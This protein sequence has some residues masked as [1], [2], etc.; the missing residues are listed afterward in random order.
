MN[1]RP[2]M[3]MKVSMFNDGQ[4]LLNHW[5]AIEKERRIPWDVHAYRMALSAWSNIGDRLHSTFYSTQTEGF[6]PTEQGLYAGKWLP[7][8]LTDIPGFSV[9]ETESALAAIGL[10]G[11][12]HPDVDHPPEPFGLI[13]TAVTAT[14]GDRTEV[15]L[16]ADGRSEFPVRYD[17]SGRILPWA[18]ISEFGTLSLVPAMTGVYSQDVMATDGLGVEVEFTLEVTV[19]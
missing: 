7:I 4:N 12:Q 6:T 3:L 17:L 16:Q 9:V 11:G 5:N 13:S 15:D 19:V 8:V 14:R 18:T 10:V 2:L 1:L